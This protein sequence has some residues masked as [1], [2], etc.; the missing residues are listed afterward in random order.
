MSFNP[1]APQRYPMAPLI[2]GT[3]VCLYLALVAPLPLLAPEPLKPWLLL[4][5]PLGL[6]LV[7]ALVSETVELDAQGLG[8]GPAPWCAWLLRRGWRADWPQIKSLVPVATSQGGRVYYLKISG[9]G[10]TESALL[11]PQRVANFEQFLSQFSLA[12]GIST[13]QVQ[14]LSPPWTYRILALLSGLMLAAELLLVIFAS[15]GGNF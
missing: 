13:D 3:L 1:N 7:L 4:L 10:Q 15:V 5:V 11:L 12:T 8:V 6:L 9:P 2:R 14:R